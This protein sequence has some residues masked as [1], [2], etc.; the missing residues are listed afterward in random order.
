MKSLKSSPK[1]VAIIAK[2]NNNVKKISQILINFGIKPL[3]IYNDEFENST[4]KEQILS[5]I[6]EQTNIFISLGGDGTLIGICRN[7]IGKDAFVMGVNAG[8]LGFLTDIELDKFDEFFK[9]FLDGKFIVENPKTLKISLVKGYVNE[10]KFAFNDFV[11]TRKD[12][13]NMSNIDAYLN[14]EYFNTY[15][16]DGVIISSPS[17]STAYNMSANGPIIHPTSEVFCVTPICS[18]SLTQRPIVLPR[19]FE[20]SFRRAENLC[21]I[22]DGQDIFSLNEYDMVSIGLCDERLNLIKN[23]KHNYFDVLKRKLNWGQYRN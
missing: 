12:V 13:V 17:G 20:I 8:N 22:I 23:P 6:L 7:L 5:E 1:I 9:D 3:I 4:K 14:D 15:I 2:P 18:H 16:G 10:T 19:G 11:V 21:I